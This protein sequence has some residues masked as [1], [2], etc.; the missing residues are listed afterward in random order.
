MSNMKEED[1]GRR[2]ELI[3][4]DDPYTNLKSGD[5]G[6]YLFCLT[7]PD[8]IHQHVISWDNGSTLML[9]QGIDSFKFIN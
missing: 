8:G 4:T 7:Q 2:V 3:S 9:L 1:K 6:T 5:K